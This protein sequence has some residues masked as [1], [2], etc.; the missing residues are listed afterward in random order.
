MAI[1][2]NKDQAS[3][4]QT[5]RFR[6]FGIFA[7][8]IILVLGGMSYAYYLRSTA[9]VVAGARV[10][11]AGAA[12]TGASDE[13]ASPEYV[14]LVRQ[15]NIEQ[16]REAEQ[17]GGSA[18][19]TAVRPSYFDSGDFE[20]RAKKGCSVKELE[21]ARESG[22]SAFELRC[23][24]CSAAALKAAG[25]TAGELAA[26]GFSASELKAAGF[27]AKELKD[28]GFSAAELKKAGFDVTNLAAA[29]YTASELAQAG[30]TPDQLRF[31]GFSDAD[32]AAAGIGVGTPSNMPKNCNISSLK[33]ARANGISAA[34]L[35]KMGCGASALKAAGFT[36]AELKAAGF[37]AAQLKAAGF[38]AKEL[39]AAGFSAG[40]L[41]KAGFTPKD[42]RAAGFSAKE[43]RDAGVSPED[44]IAA[45]FTPAELKQAGFSDGELYRAG[46]IDKPTVADA[47]QAICDVANLRK[48][49]DQGV[50]VATLIQLGCKTE[51]MQ[52]AGFTPDEI[53]GKAV[54]SAARGLQPAGQLSLAQL[55]QAAGMTPEEFLKAAQ[56]AG[57]SP[58]EYARYLANQ[59]AGGAGSDL[60]DDQLANAALAAGMTPDQFLAAARAAGM[61]PAEYARYLNAQR[62]RSPIEAPSATEEEQF[63]AQLKARQQAQLNATQRQDEIDKYTQAMRA[64]A[65]QLFSKWAPPPVQQFQMAE[66]P[67]K[68]QS[69][70]ATQQQTSQQQGQQ[71]QGQQ[72]GQQ[73][74]A[75]SSIIGPSF[76]VKAGT[77]VYGVFNTGVNSDEESPVLASVVSG[78]FSKAR[79]IGKFKLLESKLLIDFDK[80]TVPWYDKSVSVKVVAVDPETMRTAIA[81]HVCNH[82]L[83]RY[84]GLFA[85]SFLSGLAT[86]LTSSG[87]TTS[88]TTAGVVTTLPEL[89]ASEKFFVALGEV[90]TQYA[91]VLGDSFNRKPTVTIEAGQGVGFLFLEDTE[92]PLPTP[93]RR[94][95]T[96]IS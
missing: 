94:A 45:G 88:A 62:A 14:K 84:G 71:Q 76:T 12:T 10:A 77:V 25:Y 11:G 93:I 19:S 63:L 42:L 70:A 61:T 90:G 13:T 43:L 55:A 79:L 7:V 18:I 16:A 6:T 23:R 17:Q 74:Q 92:V 1:F 68:Q 96:S 72:Q 33:R 83:T 28:A 3:G 50:T 26:A 69:D 30:F 32:L 73:G 31:A 52:A 49:R 66:E 67:K 86:A 85:S 46:I 81:H 21:R 44:L 95:I 36:A 64:N 20:G 58:E 60:T 89:S 87:S 34:Q 82:Y 2:G 51:Q 59:R 35:K 40:E 75:Q 37:T 80:M 8:I 15:Q 41:L 5:S 78:R 24:G 65:A 53:A 48:M 38:S 9:G 22:V 29:G 54:Y 91:N 56:A 57:M 47:S 39:K 4:E 27:T